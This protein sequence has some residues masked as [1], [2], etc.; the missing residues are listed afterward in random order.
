MSVYYHLPSRGAV[1]DGVVDRLMQEADLP[2]APMRW[3]D[4]VKESATRFVRLAETHPHSF[5]LFQLRGISSPDAF[6]PMEAL[7]DSLIRGGFTLDDAWEVVLVF[8]NYVVAVGLGISGFGRRELWAGS[9]EP[10]EPRRELMSPE[11]FPRLHEMDTE[12]VTPASIF[13]RGLEALI[14]GFE[15]DLRRRRRRQ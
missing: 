12:S 11:D 3:Q 10:A 5:G 4:W 1:L 15:A 9:I 2:Q 6:R 14:N 13:H 8:S 7:A